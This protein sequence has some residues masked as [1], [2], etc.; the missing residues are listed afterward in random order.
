[1]TTMTRALTVEG[2]GL[3]MAAGATVM[4]NL[5][6]FLAA[7]WIGLAYVTTFPLVVTAVLIKALVKKRP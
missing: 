2:T 3:D 5:A 7:P 6:L 4:K 1:M